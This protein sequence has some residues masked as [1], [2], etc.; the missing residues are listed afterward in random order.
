MGVERL[1]EN[2]T[3]IWSFSEYEWQICVSKVIMQ[4][5]YK[6]RGYANEYTKVTGS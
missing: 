3:Y 6:L 2:I 1:G 4:G 5:E